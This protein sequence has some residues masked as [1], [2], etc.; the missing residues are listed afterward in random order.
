MSIETAVSVYPNP[1][2]DLLVIEMEKP[3]YNQLQIISMLGQVMLEK[4]ISGTKASLSVRQLVLGIYQV[5]LK[6]DNGVKVVKIEK[7]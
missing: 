6:G 7:L 2:N 5:V 4:T 3:L 1:A